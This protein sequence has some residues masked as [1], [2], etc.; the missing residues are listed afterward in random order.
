MG[1]T[2]SNVHSQSTLKIGEQ[3]PPIHIGNW[4]LNEPT[5]KSTQNKYIV[6]DFWATWCKPCLDNV[7]HLNALQ[8]SFQDENILF[9]QMTNESASTVKI[10][11]DR[12]NFE[13]PGDKEVDFYEFRKR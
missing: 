3:A 1:I 2:L 4:L 9:L 7:P 10:V 5:N 13:T 6:L 12:V 8:A 11:F